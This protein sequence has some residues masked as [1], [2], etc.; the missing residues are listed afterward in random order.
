MLKPVPKMSK[1][2][3]PVLPVNPPPRASRRRVAV[4]AA[5]AAA[6]VIVGGGVVYVL[7]PQ[8][9]RE[10]PAALQES[11]AQK[12]QCPMHPTII[13]DHPGDCPICGMKLVPMANGG[14]EVVK[15]AE[16][17]ILFYRS[18]MNP[19]ETSPVPRQDSMGMDYL[20]VYA[21]DAQSGGTVEG[22]AT[23][24]I[25]PQRQQLIGLTTAKV[26]MG[27][28]GGSWRTVGNVAMDET[29]VR[30]SNVKV[31]GFVERVYV[32]FV[33]KRVRKGDRLFSMYSPELV[34]AQSEYLLALKTREALSQA[35][36]PSAAG[37]E[38]VQSSRRRLKLWDVSDADIAAL[39]KTG[40]P[41][42]TLTVHSPI[43][44]VVT[45]KSVVEGASLAPGDM[46]YE[47]VDLST[48]W[49]LA[50]VYETELRRVR[51]GMPAE[52]TL[53]AL[54]NRVFAGKV[55]FIDPLLDAQ[56]R[57]AKVRLEF[58]N[59]AG[60][61]RPGLFGEVVLKTPEREGLRVPVDAAIPTGT[62]SVVFVSLGEGK[63]APRE[64][65]LGVR[66]VDLVEVIS[67]LSEGEEVVTRANFLV[68][69]E[70][71]LKA[72]L[73]AMSNQAP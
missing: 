43:A 19:Q 14:T 37:E 66:D 34:S 23:V 60:E 64:V 65:E 57:T 6:G 25:D 52:L 10:E 30:H 17:K 67:G 54:P 59:P 56:T 20:P 28:V 41:G 53:Q 68:D 69:S 63:F 27:A 9:P 4:V 2:E 46:P 50:D 44:G 8:A 33:G 31:A 18:P 22:L 47:I 12:Y 40:E 16:R 61:L 24:S 42:R 13:Q 5:A 71:R 26:T 62:K 48:V 3:E 35:G 15:P 36:A 55:I 73:Q 39:E 58:K 7:S 29:R 70:S 21:D 72:A 32:D 45:Q 49:V 11:A 1:D 51:E 38:L